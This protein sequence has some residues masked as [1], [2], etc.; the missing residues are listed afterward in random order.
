MADTLEEALRCPDQRLR[1][2]ERITG[3]ISRGSAFGSY[4]NF[5]SEDTIGESGKYHSDELGGPHHYY[6]VQSRIGQIT[7][8]VISKGANGRTSQEIDGATTQGLSAALVRAETELEG[9][10]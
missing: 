9:D 3:L 10:Q 6:Y 4:G 5:T 1:Q 7:V 2:G 8:T